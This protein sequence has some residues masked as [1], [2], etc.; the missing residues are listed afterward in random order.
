MNF[1]DVS[2]AMKYTISSLNFPLSHRVQQ[3]TNLFVYLLS[4]EKAKHA[5]EDLQSIPQHPSL[6]PPTRIRMMTGR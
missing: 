4:S 1:N 5:F 2:R 6:T 3:Y